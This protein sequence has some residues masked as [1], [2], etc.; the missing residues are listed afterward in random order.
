MSAVGT[1]FEMSLLDHPSTYTFSSVS[2][3]SNFNSS[4]G[5]HSG[6]LAVIMLLP[7]GMGV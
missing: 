6:R 7:L 4:E 3:C 2:L 5:G 1:D